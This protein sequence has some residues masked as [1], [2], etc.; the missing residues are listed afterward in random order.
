MSSKQ[1]ANGVQE[2]RAK[3][4]APLNLNVEAVEKPKIEKIASLEINTL[5]CLL[6]VENRVFLQPR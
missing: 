5:P 1:V 3:S 2:G 4:G 6:F